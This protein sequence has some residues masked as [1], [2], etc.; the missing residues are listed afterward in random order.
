VLPLAD[1]APGAAPPPLLLLLLALLF[2]PPPPQA[3]TAIATA[4]QRTMGS[5]F[6][7]LKRAGEGLMTFSFQ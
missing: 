7:R 4:A 3:M 6:S 2:E 1:G 5:N